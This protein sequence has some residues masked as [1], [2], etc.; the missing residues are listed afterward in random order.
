M[1]RWK[2]DMRVIHRVVSC[3]LLFF[4]LSKFKKNCEQMVLMVVIMGEVV[5]CTNVE[6]ETD[7]TPLR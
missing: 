1:F 2:K 4:F 7:T 5:M 6:A 3:T